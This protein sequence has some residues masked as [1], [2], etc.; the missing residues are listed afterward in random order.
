MRNFLQTFIVGLLCFY[1][2]GGGSSTVN[3]GTVMTIIGT[4]VL[5]L[6]FCFGIFTS[7]LFGCRNPRPADMTGAFPVRRLKQPERAFAIESL[8]MRD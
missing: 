1:A 8:R 6:F 3:V 7:L 5:N 2:A 4:G